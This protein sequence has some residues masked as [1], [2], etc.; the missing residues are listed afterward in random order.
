H[1]V[2]FMAAVLSSELG[3]GEKAAHFIAECEAM[4]VQV[5]GPDVNESR[6]NF[7]PVFRRRNGAGVES[8]KLKVESNASNGSGLS[9]LN[10]QLSTANGGEAAIRFGLAAVK[11]VG[12][13]AAQKIIAERD[14]HG[15]F[16]DF[17][18]LTAR[19]DG[20]A[21]NK[22]VLE[23]LIKTGAFD[24][25]GAPRKQLFDHIDEAIAGAA[26][27]ARD[28]AAGQHSFLDSL[29]EEPPKNGG[30]ASA[31][32]LA[33]RPSPLA[34]AANDFSSYD[35]LTFEK[36]L[37]GFYISGH[38]MNQFAGLADALDT[39]AEDQLLQQPD[40]AEFRICGIAGNI[41]KKLSKK[42]NRPWAAFTLATR[43]ATVALN[44]FA[45]AFE[46]YGS[47]LAENAPVLV[48]GNIIQGNDGPRL[49]IKECQPLEPA[50]SG[51]V[52]KV[53]WLLHP[54]HPELIDF[55]RQLRAAVNTASGDT[56]LELAFVF[57]GRV[58]PMADASPGL[59]WKLTSQSFQ[60][61]R[62][63]PA[64]AGVQL[65]TKKLELKPDRR[66]GKR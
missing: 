55:L 24:F 12:E 40:R 47:S 64:V 8:S 32:P 22:R 43:R 50:V 29:A 34:S 27:A 48:K 18:D 21:I 2:Q 54:A 52:K 17:T 9:T 61:L 63:H 37:L 11:G 23:H 33:S 51:L 26:S 15:P 14:T 13:A 60:D 59:T 42:D 10:P 35:R 53:T 38:P 6:E 49:N 1:P 4:G 45:D 5:L 65:E 36:E 16:R 66:W 30:H 31:L 44:M 28:K 3:N 25:S 20:R 41:T 7:T 19:V 62:A 39:C 46:A 57:D 58:A 56:R